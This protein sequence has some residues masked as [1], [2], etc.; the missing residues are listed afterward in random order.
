MDGSNLLLLSMQAEEFHQVRN[1]ERV[2]VTREL[3]RQNES[4]ED[5][6]R[7][8]AIQREGARRRRE[9]ESSENRRLRLDRDRERRRLRKNPQNE[10]S[11]DRERRLAINRDRLDYLI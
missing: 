6:E 7:R 5:R 8:L 9:N 10:S 11:E 2:R 4:S 1:N 3:R